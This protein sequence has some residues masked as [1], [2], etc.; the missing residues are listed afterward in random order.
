MALRSIKKTFVRNRMAHDPSVPNK[1]TSAIIENIETVAADAIRITFSNRV[2]TAKLP[3]YKAGA[4]G[5]QAVTSMERVSYTV[6]EFTFAGDVA[7]TDL[8]VLEGDL[9]IRTTSGGFV[10]AGVYAI[11]TFP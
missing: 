4:D 9:G 3:G 11:P 2:M 10:P 5:E 8:H 7:G 1:N 6:I